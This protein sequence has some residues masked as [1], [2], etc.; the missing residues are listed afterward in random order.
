[1]TSDESGVST[2]V[3][4]SGFASTTSDTA[5]APPAPCLLTTTTPFVNFGFI[6]SATTRETT[7]TRPPPGKPAMIVSGRSGYCAA[8]GSATPSAKSAENTTRIMRP[9]LPGGLNARFLVVEVFLDMVQHLVADLVFAPQPDQFLPLGLHR[10]VPQTPRVVGDAVPQHQTS[11]H[12]ERDF[13]G[14]FGADALGELVRDAAFRRHGV[15][16][17]DRRLAERHLGALLL[18]LQAPVPADLEHAD[19][20]LQSQ[21]LQDEGHRDDDES[22]KDDQVALGEG[23]SF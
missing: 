18:L 22:V 1:M 10:R 12:R 4:P 2:I 15:D 7:S 6:P 11:R 3:A 8:Q 9:P 21:P 13:L 17:G 23:A 14:E 19:E 16:G 20:R 5:T